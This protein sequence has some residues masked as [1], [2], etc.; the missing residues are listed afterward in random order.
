[1][2]RGDEVVE[3]TRASEAIMAPLDMKMLGID[4]ITAA[5]LLRTQAPGCPPSSSRPSA[6]RG[7]SRVPCRPERRDPS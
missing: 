1:M 3:A 4:G 5:S 6:V 7:T 2:G